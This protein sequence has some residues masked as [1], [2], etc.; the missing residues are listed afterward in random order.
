MIAL[1]FRAGLRQTRGISP[2]VHSFA[3]C[4]TFVALSEGFQRSFGRTFH[5]AVTAAR[6]RTE[7]KKQS[8][9]SKGSQ[10]G[11]PRFENHASLLHSC[12]MCVSEMLSAPPRMPPEGG[13]REKQKTTC[14]PASC[15]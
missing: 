4:K 7:N 3:G 15:A 6:K 2:G 9:Q 14:S 11:F 5:R 10:Q 8:H 1:T 12:C 13:R